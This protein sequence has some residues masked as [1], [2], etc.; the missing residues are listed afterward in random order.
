[1]PCP[2]WMSE[3]SWN[4]SVWISCTAACQRMAASVAMS[5]SGSNTSGRSGPAEQSGQVRGQRVLLDPDDQLRGVVV[6]GH[7]QRGARAADHRA[8]GVGLEAAAPML[9]DRASVH[10]HVHRVLRAE[11]RDVDGRGHVQ[12]EVEQADVAQ[13]HAVHGGREAGHL[14]GSDRELE[15]PECLGDQPGGCPDVLGVEDLVVC[16]RRWHTAGADLAP[17]RVTGA[18]NVDVAQAGEPRHQGCLS[19]A[20]NSRWMAPPSTAPGTRPPK[21]LSRF[22]A[23]NSSQS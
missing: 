4:T 7:P 1:M 5:N 22:N 23:D 16:Q 9:D 3:P 11:H 10:R 17:H 14:V 12:V 21:H 15:R 19:C 2:R 13:S 8:D 6:E 18:P 20:G